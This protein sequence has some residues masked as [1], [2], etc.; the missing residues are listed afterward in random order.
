MIRIVVEK[1]EWYF[2][3]VDIIG[4]L[5]E[6]GNSNNYLKLLKKIYRLRGDLVI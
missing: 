2:G 3:V 6:S 1:E 5:S 4:V